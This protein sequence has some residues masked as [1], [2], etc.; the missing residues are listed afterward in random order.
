MGR[1]SVAFNP[2]NIAPKLTRSAGQ[3]RLGL[4]GVV[5]VAAKKHP[6]AE[7]PIPS[8]EEFFS[9]CSRHFGF[10]VEEC[11]YTTQKLTILGTVAY[12]MSYEKRGKRLKLS[13]EAREFVMDISFAD[14]ATMGP[15]TEQYLDTYL[16][17][18]ERTVRGVPREGWDMDSI[19]GRSARYV[20][21]NASDLL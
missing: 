8:P 10:M 20:K 6:Y 13:Y 2:G 5:L 17:S 15:D 19:V 7:L 16:R 4:Q 18:L 14:E 9:A 3:A 11:G 21:L 12:I 1:V